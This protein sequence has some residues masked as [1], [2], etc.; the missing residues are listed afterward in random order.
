M[1]NRPL[2]VQIAESLG[3]RV[4]EHTKRIGEWWMERTCISAPSMLELRP[5]PDY[6]AFLRTSADARCKIKGTVLKKTAAEAQA[7]G[8]P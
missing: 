2:N 8:R 3:W 5:V 6:I 4:W 1:D 7:M